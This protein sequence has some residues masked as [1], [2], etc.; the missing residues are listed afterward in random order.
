MIS[1]FSSFF[2]LNETITMKQMTNLK[3]VN[4]KMS[5]FFYAS[6]FAC[7]LFFIFK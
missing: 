1:V 6:Y 5:T 7:S 4:V 3:N 2:E